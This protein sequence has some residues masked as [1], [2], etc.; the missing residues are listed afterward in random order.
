MLGDSFKEDEVHTCK[1]LKGL[2]GNSAMK[3]LVET[4]FQEEQVA[5]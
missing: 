3:D 1:K 5:A 4:R 2:A